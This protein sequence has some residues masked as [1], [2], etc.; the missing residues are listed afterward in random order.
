MLGFKFR[1]DGLYFTTFRKPTS[2][3]L[4]MTFPIPPYT[5]IRGLISNALGMRRDDFSI[6]DW[7]KIGINPLYFSNQSR[8]MAKILKLKG[9]GNTY[10]RYFP[11]SPMFKEFLVFP[12][13]DIYIAGRDDKISRIFDSLHNPAR[14]LYIGSSDDFV[15]IA[16][17]E[18]IEVE[19]A[20]ENKICGVMSEIH[21]NSLVERVPYKFIK[22]GKRISLEYQT[23]C[24]PYDS[25]TI[26]NDAV[27]C[28]K[29][30]GENVWM[31]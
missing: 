17:T 15:D 9:T 5:T 21:E 4:I 25:P 31:I 18:I 8:E 2:T 29:F 1:L 10:S 27:R 20:E 26:V 23:V 13:Y 12:A 28:W 14:P 3:S 22:D 24:I 19:E 6:Q 30:G 11:S 7:I 16:P